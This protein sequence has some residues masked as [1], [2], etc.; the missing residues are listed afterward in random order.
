MNPGRSRGF[1]KRVVGTP[2]HTSHGVDLGSTEMEEGPVE[3]PIGHETYWDTRNEPEQ[4]WPPWFPKS[5]EEEDAT[6]AHRE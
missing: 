2:N 3:G 4:M 6:N 5:G 1:R